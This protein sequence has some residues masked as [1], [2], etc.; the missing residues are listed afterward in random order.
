MQTVLRL[1][2]CAAVVLPL[3]GCENHSDM[4]SVAD[5][6]LQGVGGIGGSDDIARSKVVSIPYAT[7]GVRLGSSGEAMFVLESRSGA[8]LQWVGGTQLALATRDGRILRTAGFVHNL[9]GFHDETATQSSPE[10]HDYRY[11]LADINA[12]GVL[13]RCK[14]HDAGQEQVTI[15]GELHSTHH[16]IEDCAAP[17]LEWN[18]RNEFWRDTAS[19]IV[20]RSIQY[21]HPGLDP[22]SLETLRP[23]G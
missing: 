8:N 14:D 5:L 19:G 18:F 2:L 21:V 15:I 20:W 6:I 9:S 11:D 13:V 3:G 16:L 1:M 22:V 17:D 10:T 23:S 12:Y 4:V 7:L